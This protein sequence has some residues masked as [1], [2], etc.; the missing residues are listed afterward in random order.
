MTTWQDPRKWQRVL[1]RRHEACHHDGSSRARVRAAEG[2]P[3]QHVTSHELTSGRQSCRLRKNNG[4]L[5]KSGKGQEGKEATGKAKERALTSRAPTQ[6]PTGSASNVAR[7]TNPR[8]L[9]QKHGGRK[10]KRHDE[11]EMQKDKRASALE[12]QAQFKESLA[13]S[14]ARAAP[15]LYAAS[16]DD[17]RKGQRS[18]SSFQ[19]MSLASRAGTIAVFGYGSCRSQMRPC[20]TQEHKLAQ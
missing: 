1:V 15:R 20:W 6:T 4:A 7:K 10:R 14:T 19:L 17:L 9:P 2:H 5:A 12:G 13:G 11:E 18:D 16:E 3:P 8:R